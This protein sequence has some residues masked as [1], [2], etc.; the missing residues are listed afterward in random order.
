[1]ELGFKDLGFRF[2]KTLKSQKP[3]L[4]FL[5]FIF[6]LCNLISTPHIQNKHNCCLLALYITVYAQL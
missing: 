2:L 6:L 4:G 1:M 3:N 5:V